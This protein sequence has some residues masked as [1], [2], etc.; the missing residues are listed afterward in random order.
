M[1]GSL[2]VDLCDRDVIKGT[3][4]GLHSCGDDWHLLSRLSFPQDFGSNKRGFGLAVVT[5]EQIEFDLVVLV[6]WTEGGE[7]RD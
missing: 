5:A 7:T 2:P 6:V 4:G 3:S 1:S